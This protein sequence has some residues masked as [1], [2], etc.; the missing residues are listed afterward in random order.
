[1]SVNDHHPHATLVRRM[2]ESLNRLDAGAVRGCYH[3]NATFHD[4]VLSLIGQDQIAALWA[5]ICASARSSGTL[6]SGQPAGVRWG[7]T[8][9]TLS[10]D[11]TH[12]HADWDA[13]D[14]YAGAGRQTQTRIRSRFDFQDGLI[15]RQCDDFQFWRWAHQALGWRGTLLGWTPM[16]RNSVRTQ[17]L[18]ALVRHMPEVTPHSRAEMIRTVPPDSAGSRPKPH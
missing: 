12:G 16:V 6:P 9:R 7:I 10:A 5:M 13:Y 17:A 8:L 3:P 2:F 14:R 1:M 18:S 15:L 11:E 4:P